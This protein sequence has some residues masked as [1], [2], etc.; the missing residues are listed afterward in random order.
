MIFDFAQSCEMRQKGYG[1]STKGNCEKVI[2]HSHAKRS[3]R[4]KLKLLDSPLR[5]IMRDHLGLVRKCILS[6]FLDE[7]ASG[8]PLKCCQV[9]FLLW[10]INRNGIYSFRDF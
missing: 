6:R 3:R 8:R 1:C 5:T 10:P 9:S 2:S 7:E 4:T